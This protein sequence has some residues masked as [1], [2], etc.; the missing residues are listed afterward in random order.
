VVL[1][2]VGSAASVAAE[3]P[4][5]PPRPVPDY[6]GRPEPPPST[7][8]RLLWIPRVGLYPL[9]VV[10]EYVI[11]RPLG[12]VVSNVEE[13]EIPQKVMEFFTFGAEQQGAWAPTLLIDFGFRPSAGLYFKYDQ[14]FFE[15]NGIRVHFATWG[16]DWISAT[17]ADRIE[18]EGSP[19]EVQ[20]RGEA[21]RRPD[22]LFFGIGSRS[23]DEL[24]SRYQWRLLDLEWSFRSE[25]FW[26]SSLFQA[27]TG[28]RDMEFGTDTCCSGLPVDE[29]VQRGDF[30]ALPP[31]FEQGYFIYRQ[32]ARFSVDTRR[33]RP[34]AG[35]GVN[36]EVWGEHSFDLES[37]VDRRWLRYGGSAGLYVDLTGE[38][39]VLS[40]TLSTSLVEPLSGEIPFTELVELGGEGPMRAFRNGQLIG[41]STLAAIAEYRWPIWMWLDASLHVALGNVYDGQ[42]EQFELDGARLSFGAGVRSSN[43]RDHSFDLMLAF[44]TEP[45]DEGGQ[46]E[47]VRFV[48]GGTRAF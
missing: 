25:E 43:E 8:D 1:A 12:F 33:E 16:P 14:L 24:R 36:L 41:E 22:G 7:A 48:F 46:I 47:S 10:S 4:N 2:T 18:P 31:G 6:D 23:A 30:E 28:I 39:N 44:G 45:L 32:G 29:R 35:T 37:P 21:T 5:R 27:W 40:A 11:R 17:V 15:E 38:N 34:A 3:E 42:F 20:L 9:Y 26:R 13:K 19:W